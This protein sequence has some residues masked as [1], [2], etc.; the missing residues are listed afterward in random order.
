MAKLWRVSYTSTNAGGVQAVNVFHFVDRPA[1]GFTTT[2]SA[3]AVRDALNTALTTL[4]RLCIANTWTVG[5]LVVA[6]VLTPGSTD[7][8]EEASITIGSVGS[9]T[10][11]GDQLPPPICPLVTFYT[12]AAIRSG[13]G[14]CFMP[15]PG[16]AAVLAASGAWDIT[17]APFAAAYPNFLTALRSAIH[18][19]VPVDPDSTL[20]QVVYSRTRHARG[21]SQYYFDVVSANLRLQPHWLRSRMTAP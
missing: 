11:S 12:N 3:A 19:D 15:N 18:P 5:A 1:S 21:D 2:G 10:T 16:N 14:R 20:S 9:I 13:H 6:E 7:V 17:A 4:Y 8:P